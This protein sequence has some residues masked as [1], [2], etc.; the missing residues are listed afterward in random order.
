MFLWS[1]ARAKVWGGG[2]GR[3]RERPG[4]DASSA[5]PF[6]TA[7][8]GVRGAHMKRAFD[9]IA[10]T[11]GLALLSPI[12]AVLALAILVDDPGPI[13]FRG[14]RVGRDGREFRI[15]KFRS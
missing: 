13:I 5:H 11:V 12:V 4:T 3:L 2:R 8:P 6:H 14:R 7:H 15:Y 1:L 9:I 10:A